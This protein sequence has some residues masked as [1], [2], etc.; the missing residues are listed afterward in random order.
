ML[1]QYIIQYYSFVLFINCILSGLQIQYIV[2]TI[3]LYADNVNIV[4]TYIGRDLQKKTETQFLV[5]ILKFF[6]RFQF[7]YRSL[8]VYN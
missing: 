1:V 6:H 3:Y 5:F 4:Q 8:Q 7:N 2:Y